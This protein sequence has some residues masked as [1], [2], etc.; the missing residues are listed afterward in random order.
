MVKSLKILGRVC[1]IEID[2]NMKADEGEEVP[3]GEYK[4]LHCSIHLNPAVKNAEQR[5][6]T[7][8]HE[9]IH[10]GFDVSGLTNLFDIKQEEAICSMMEQVVFANLDAFIAIRKE[11]I[12]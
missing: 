11:K 5:C 2:P 7:V 12:K 9:A 1:P 8:I 3:W 4:P 6:R 10:A